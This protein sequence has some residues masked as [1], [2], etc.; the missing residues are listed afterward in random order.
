MVT[1]IYIAHIKL[2][3]VPTP[4]LCIQPYSFIRHNLLSLFT[5]GLTSSVSLFVYFQKS[6]LSGNCPTGKMLKNIIV[7]T[8]EH[9]QKKF[10]NRTSI[11]NT[12]RTNRL[13]HGKY[14]Y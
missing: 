6:R 11:Q 5:S 2:E 12:T 8:I 1:Y 3:F 13:F 9:K 4:T 14:E 10:T 7:L